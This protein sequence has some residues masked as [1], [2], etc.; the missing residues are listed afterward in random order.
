MSKEILAIVAKY[1]GLMYTPER[2]EGRRRMATVWIFGEDGTDSI[3]GLDAAI[4]KGLDYLYSQAKW[5]AFYA[6]RDM[7]RIKSAFAGGKS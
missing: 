3:A 1:P 5:T 7:K 6:R 2:M 4:N